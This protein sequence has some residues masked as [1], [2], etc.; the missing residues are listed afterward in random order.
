MELKEV[1]KR[2]FRVM[3]AEGA[4][5]FTGMAFIDTTSV[6]PIFIDTYTKSMQ[7][8]GLANTIKMSV[9]LLIQLLIGPHVKSIKDVPTFLTRISFIFR[10]L[11]LLML[12]VLLLSKNPYTIVGTFLAIFACLWASDG[13]VYIPWLDLFSRTI[14]PNKRGKLLGYQQLVSGIG[15]LGSG[16]IIK[17]TLQ[18]TQ[19]SNGVKY[20]II[21][22][23]SAF[24]LFLSAVMM[25]LVK[26][27]PRVIEHE[28]PSYK[29]YFRK[30][31]SHLRKNKD[32]SQ[33][34]VI[35][36]INSI[37]AML[38]PFIILFCKNTF[39]LTASQVST[40]IYIQII[41][42][43]IGGLFWGMISQKL[44]NKYVIILCQT[45]SLFLSG[46]SLT[47]MIFKNQ[48]SSMLLLGFI[49]LLS[50]FSI[51]G[52][53]LGFTN[54]TIDIIPE[55]ER[56]TYFVLTSIITFPFTLASYLAGVIIDV[57]GFA[58]LFIICICAAVIN[59]PLCA[60][61]KSPKQIFP[62]TTV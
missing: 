26:D 23:L 8:A 3:I 12:P 37:T 47:A 42:S 35:Q 13:I 27:V 29:E 34:I 49:T 11:P 57:W 19:I 59:L 60:R 31:P 54:Y 21:F 28:K 52:S 53:W 38:Y 24:F 16:F 1:Q 18:N 14:H 45:A 62:D 58:V 17:Y 7:L 22:G 40:L 41:G 15:G 36:L 46:I 56:P 48:L 9:P 10:P 2:N 5:F 39:A 43:L 4:L 51:G 44:G 20:S 55:T 50:G 30:L 33:M 61:L 25:S 32:Y 6:I